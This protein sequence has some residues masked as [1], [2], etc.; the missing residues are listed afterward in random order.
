MLRTLGRRAREV[1][2]AFAGTAE[3]RR[4]QKET[5]AWRRTHLSH[6]LSEYNA[7]WPDLAPP[8]DD[9]LF[10]LCAGWRTGSTFV[11]RLAA[12]SGERLVWGEVFDRSSILQGMTDQLRP[13]SPDWPSQD[14]RFDPDRPI[15]E[16]FSARLSPE[17]EQL[18]VAHRAMFDALLAAPAHVRG[19]ERWGAKEV[20]LDAEHAYY[21]KWLYPNA[22]ILFLVRNPIHCWRS[23]RP[24]RY[25]HWHWPDDQ[26]T[27]PQAFGRHWVQL[28]QSYLDHADDLGALLCK[29]E[30]LKSPDFHEEFVAFLGHD[31]LEPEALDHIQ[32]QG[33]KTPRDIPLLEKRLLWSEVGPTAERFGYS[34]T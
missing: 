15:H 32:G 30:D 20:R 28:A 2:R 17:G 34:L 9:P 6:V 21:L 18:R 19:F 3:A 10:V 7:R 25:W 16:W 23:Y 1:A 5:K 14:M 4:F 13:F 26:V 31:V 29:Y 22:R 27:T 33:R 12:S 11:Q 8:P 24:K